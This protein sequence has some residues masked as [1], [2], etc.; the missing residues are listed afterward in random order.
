MDAACQES[1][2]CS[3]TLHSSITTL[4]FILFLD[5]NFYIH[6]ETFKFKEFSLTHYPGD[7]AV[8]ISCLSKYQ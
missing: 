7:D 2:G 3:Y 5:H 4:C 6:N 8:N 1:P